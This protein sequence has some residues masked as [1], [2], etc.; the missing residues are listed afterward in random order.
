MRLYILN[1][2]NLIPALF[3]GLFTG[4]A[5]IIGENFSLVPTRRLLLL[6]VSMLFKCGIFRDAYDRLDAIRYLKTIP[7]YQDRTDI[8]YKIE[9]AIDCR[10]E[11]SEIERYAPDYSMA[12]K[13][14]SVSYVRPLLLLPFAIRE[15][16][17]PAYAG[18]F[19][20]RGLPRDILFFYEQYFGEKPSCEFSLEFELRRVVNGVNALLTVLVSLAWIAAK[21]RAFPARPRRRPLGA[22]F[23]NSFDRRGFRLIDGISD[24]ADD[25]VFVFRSRRQMKSYRSSVSRFD[26][27]CMGDGHFPFALGLRTMLET[28]SDWWTLCR[29]AFGL[30]SP[31]FAQIIRLPIR[32]MRFRALFQKYRFDSFMSRDDY[33]PDHCLRSQELRMAGTR[34]LGIMHGM[35]LEEIVQ[36]S[37]RFIDFDF[38]YMFA[39]GQY[40]TLYKERFGKNT[41]ARAIGPWG[42][43]PEQIARLKEPRPPN[44]IYFGRGGPN[45][46]IV[47]DAFLTAARHFTDRTFYIKLK[48]GMFRYAPDFLERLE[49]LPDNVVNVDPDGDTYELMLHARYA[50]GTATTALCEAIGYGLAG[51]AFDVYPGWYFYCREFPGLCVKTADELIARIEN[52]EAGTETYQRHLYNDLIEPCVGNPFETIRRDMGL[53]PKNSGRS[54]Q[55]MSTEAAGG[56]EPIRC[57]A[58]AA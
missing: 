33:N 58:P 56:S 34:S 57:A 2:F 40:R 23:T 22:D 37:M 43:T 20:F 18:E 35:A 10:Y 26:I 31:L 47:L 4:P 3:D 30:S 55:G 14:C 8:F 39:A 16:C 53:G 27:A 51:F 41:I 7:A 29:R 28:I 11:F 45:E 25:V 1:G 38:Y 17:K 24:R 9:G 32:R 13:H 44:A 21:L 42:M 19:A 49:S 15:L 12:Y 36:P 46:W 52:L 48:D 5:F 6:A 54:G 50:I